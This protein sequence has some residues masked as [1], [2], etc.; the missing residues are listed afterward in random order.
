MAAQI[1][2]AIAVQMAT[3]IE[4]IEAP[5]EGG[6]SPIKVS[7]LRPATTPSSP[8]AP[9]TN[10]SVALGLVVGLVVGIVLAVV[11]EQFDITVKSA[12]DAQAI[13]G[14]GVIGLVGNNPK[15]GKEP[16]I[17]L[18]SRAARAEA[19][20]TI[21]TN[22][23]FT[24]VDH[25]P[26]RIVISSAIAGEGKSVTAC[27]L[28][29]A[30]A[31]AGKRVCLVEA[32]LRRPKVAEYLGIEGSVGLTNVL[33]G[34]LSLDDA[35]IGW[36]DGLVTVLSAGTIPP[37]PSEL[38]S[39]KHMESVLASLSERFDTLL[40]DAPPLLPVTDAAILARQA[41]GALLIAR[42]GHVKKD[43]LR[44][45]AEALRMAKARLIGVV[46]TFVPVRGSGTNYAQLHGYGTN[47]AGT[48]LVKP[49][50]LNGKPIPVTR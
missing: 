8:S 42:H 18:Q 12:Q 28:A 48:E 11:R 25:P 45:A 38:L 44:D 7:L 6:T 16:L 19:F 24:D 41:D 34:Q 9:L 4:S 20:R 21:R 26:K 23:Q 3:M 1:A 47:Q 22:L 40:I 43:Q 49:A 36:N 33:A 50:Q 27:N 30:L 39:S 5:K 17:A 14:V 2:N 31:Q 29:I 46:L 15:S 10:L 35:L 37:D 13:A 32:D